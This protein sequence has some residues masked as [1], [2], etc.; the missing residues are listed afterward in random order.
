MVI[1]MNKL[2]KTIISVFLSFLLFSFGAGAEKLPEQ[3]GNEFIHVKG[4]KIYD[5]DNNEFM[6]KGISLGNSVWGNLSLPN[7]KHHTEESY[8][9]LSELGFNSVRFYMNYKLFEDDS[10]PYKYKQSGFDWLDLNIRWAKKHNIGLILNMHV[11]QGGY[12]SQ[13]DGMDLWT[14][15]K[16]QNRLSALWKE[17]AER[18]ENEPAVIG[19]SLINE[20][21]IP[22]KNT[23]KESVNAFNDYISRLVKTIRSADKNH[24]LFIE[25]PLMVKN[26]ETGERLYGE[27]GELSHFL[28]DDDNTVYEYHDYS[29]FSYTHQ[30]LEFAD[31][32]GIVKYYP[33]DEIISFVNENTVWLGAQTAVETG[34]EE[35][36]WVYCESKP[37]T[38]TQKYNLGAVSCQVLNSG[39]SGTA[40][41]D[42]ITITEYDNK[43]N[44]T[45]IITAGYNDKPDFWFWSS[46]GSGSYGH[47]DTESYSGEGSLFIK[48]VTGD[49]NFAGKTFELKEGC[50]YTV[51]A[52]VK[53]E[54]CL[55]WTKAV[56]R[57]DF[58]KGSDIQS[59]NRDYLEANMKKNIEFGIKNNVPVYLGEFGVNNEAFIYERGAPDFI[60]D[61]IELCKEYGVHFN[62]HTYH[63][64]TFGLY[65]NSDFELPGNKN[66]KLA[67]IFKEKL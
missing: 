22:L 41:F 11:P 33:S 20:P 51:S 53:Q 3:K 45:E 26:T 15:V 56:P 43:G 25:R 6:L 5:R 44:V 58:I 66:T 17:I 18:Y 46:N 14:Q 35:N 12:Q 61:M 24:I 31:T 23:V 52:W 27:P 4:N 10:Q 29:P 37:V 62:Y 48:G 42:R 38:R 7:R 50:E 64:Q 59:V 57:I 30:N 13:G 67:E 47:T 16:N 9:E 34:S 19:Y 60:T 40:Y 54:N 21:S 55:D 39:E 65:M 8:K 32:K 2:F 63:E 49:S 36:G 28:V 1:I